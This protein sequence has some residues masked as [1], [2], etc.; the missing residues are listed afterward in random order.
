MNNEDAEAAGVS[1][2]CKS[3]VARQWETGYATSAPINK[4]VHPFAN[5]RM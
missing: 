5:K 2:A 1:H 4:R 3:V